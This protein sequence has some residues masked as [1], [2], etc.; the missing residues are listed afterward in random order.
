MS[1][2]EPGTVLFDRYRV[3]RRI[4][5]GGMGTVFEALDVVLDQP[6][7]LKRVSYAALPDELAAETRERTLREARN[8][9]Q[10]R[11]VAHVVAIY[12]VQVS[13]DDVWLVLEYLPSRSLAELTAGRT[14]LDVRTVAGVGATVARGLA[15]AHSRGI[16]HRDVKPGNILIADEGGTAKLT[17]FGISHAEGE[18]TLTATGQVS[19]TP[20]YMARE[21][22][23][24]EDATPASDV[25][26]LA[27]TLYAA[28]EGVGPFGPQSNPRA[29]VYRVANDPIRPPEQ[30][31]PL[32]PVLIAMMA[33]EPSRRPDA[34]TVAGWLESVASDGDRAR[35]PS[36]PA[37]WAPS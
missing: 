27:A 33:D 29:M 4:A 22:A 3:V 10:M 32:A 34:A 36:A 8:A 19:G 25:F 5:A 13:D 24:G 1:A 11:G 6:V 21:V 16:T 17:D 35:G 30:A 37:R 2:A 20:A 15:A 7:A 28:V 14:T 31:G 12:D 26:S 9:A 18:S 23:R